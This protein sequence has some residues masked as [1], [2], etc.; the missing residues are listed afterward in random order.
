MCVLS[1][2]IRTTSNLGC[3]FSFFSQAAHYGCGCW[4]ENACN[5]NPYS[6][7]VSTSG[8]AQHPLYPTLQLWICVCA[9]ATFNHAVPVY[10]LSALCLRDDANSK[11]IYLMW[12][13]ELTSMSQASKSLIMLPNDFQPFLLGD[14]RQS[15][16]RLIESSFSMLC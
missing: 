2:N 6:T 14:S 10:H 4:A 12:T 1:R 3:F 5:M 16:P 9:C 15:L 13:S 7:A 8:I 11:Q